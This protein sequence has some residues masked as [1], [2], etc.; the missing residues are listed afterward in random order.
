MSDSSLHIRCGDDILATLKEAGLP[1]E[2]IRWADAL[3]QGPT[4]AGLGKTQWRKVRAEH[5]RDFYG[6]P[7]DEGAEFLRQQDDNLQRYRE[8]DDIVLWF[9]HDMFD[10][11]ILIYLLNWFAQ[12]DLG[13]RRLLLI[14][15]NRHLGTMKA[16]ELMKLY[17]TRR[18]VTAGQIALARRA[19]EAFCSTDP[20]H[21]ETLIAEDTSALPYLKAALLRHLQEFPSVRN[22]LNQTEQFALEAVAS[23]VT[24]PKQLFLTI[25]RREENAWLG[26]SMF[27]PYVEQMAAGEESLL[28]I[29]GSG[30]WVGRHSQAPTRVVRLTERGGEVLE[31]HAD[32]V[33]LKGIN[34]WIGGVHLHGNE[35]P[36]RWDTEQCTLVR[37]H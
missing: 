31:G 1:G 9:E 34:R 21:I 10:Q 27:W 36:W 16:D 33:S 14:C 11:V 3:C 30:P 8:H 22:G 4:P 15:H 12:Q 17:P 37:S 20:R 29:Q 18:E 7:Y 5:A 24:E 26:D 25:Q 6:M 32:W 2:M 19:W 35:I 23:G 28:T 13:R